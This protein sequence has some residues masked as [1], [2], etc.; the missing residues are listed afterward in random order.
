ML[1]DMG[2]YHTSQISFVSLKKQTI[3]RILERCAEKLS[4]CAT[5]ALDS[6]VALCLTVWR[7]RKKDVMWPVIGNDPGGLHLLN[8]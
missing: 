7:G 6:L 8:P 3:V 5:N 1:V 4:F 2:S